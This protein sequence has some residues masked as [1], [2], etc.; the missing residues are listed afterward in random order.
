MYMC[1]DLHVCGNTFNTTNT[2]RDSA[3]E[4]RGQG[5]SGSR[6]TEST[7][8]WKSSSTQSM[9]L[10][11]RWGGLASLRTVAMC[12]ALMVYTRTSVGRGKTT[13]NIQQI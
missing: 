13:H 3:H 7:F 8:F 2:L 9:I 11:M 12:A 10:M 4:G 1:Q 6:V 5:R